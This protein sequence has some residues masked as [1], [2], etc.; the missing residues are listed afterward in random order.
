MNMG[1]SDNGETSPSTSKIYGESAVVALAR[2]VRAA[3]ERIAPYI[4]RTPTVR[5][6]WLDADGREV[7]GKLECWQVSG[8]FKARGAFN[9]LSTFGPGQLS[10][11]ASAGNHGLAVAAAAQVLGQSARVFVPTSASELKVRRIVESGAAITVVG[12]DLREATDQAVK[13]AEEHSV[14]F[15]SPYANWDV[16]AGQ[17]TC[18]AEAVQDVG[19]FDTVIVPLGGGGLLSGVGAYAADRLPGTHLIA[20]HPAVFNRPF[21]KH[22]VDACLRMATPP[23]YADGLAVQHT[24]A[25]PLAEV[26]NRLLFEICAVT[27]S[28][29]VLGI[30]ALLHEHSL[31]VEGAG[32]TATAALLSGKVQARTGRTLLVLSGGNISSSALARAVVTEV[33]DKRLR[34]ALGLRHYMPVLESESGARS[35]GRDYGDQHHIDSHDVTVL[36]TETETFNSFPDGWAKRSLELEDITV[37]AQDH[38]NYL[39]ALALPRTGMQYRVLAKLQ[40]L[41]EELAQSLN[42]LDGGVPQILSGDQEDVVRLLLR[43]RETLSNGLE[44]ASP[45]YDQSGRVNFYDPSAQAAGGVNYARYGT[46]DLRTLELGL[47]EMLGFAYDGLEVLATSS[48]MAAFQVIESLLLRHVLGPGDVVAYAPYIYFE[49]AEEF[50]GLHFLG[51]IRATG[52]GSDELVRVVEDNNARVLFVDPVNNIAGLPVVD[53]ERLANLIESR[54]GWADRWLVIDGTMVSGGVNVFD[55]FCAPGHPRVLYYES[56]SKYSQFGLDLQMAGVCVVPREFAAKARSIRRNTGTILYP[57][58]VARFPRADRAAYLRRMRRMSAN[59]SLM[60]SI[61]REDERIAPHI[62]IGCVDDWMEREWAH[63]GAVL[64]IEFRQTGLNNRDG[65]EAV[66]ERMLVSARAFSA[67]LVKGLSFGFST[68]RVS[69]ASSMAEGSDPF[70]RFSVGI[71]EPGEVRRLASIVASAVA[72]Y[73]EIFAPVTAGLLVRPPSEHGSPSTNQVRV[74]PGI[75]IR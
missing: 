32:A 69:A 53:L 28:E 74:V 67:P 64:T 48:G 61:L 65:L 12:R 5:L 42:P 62:H 26:L 37:R 18:L 50:Q 58:A 29:I 51:H 17:G 66:I 49:A 72:D 20:T 6:P 15:I 23:T 3:H 22:S 11:T 39:D 35:T 36:P 45:A 1:G 38:R 57:D 31:L 54:A 59:A 40:T 60:A 52:Y 4:V 21:D 25:N 44:W 46:A 34:T 14:P 30:Y 9:A 75:G 8:S 43:M 71:E 24:F 63:G 10:I 55:L 56:A 68:T 33:D 27:E 13:Y 73:L 70:L 41:A 7:W 16:A 19:D 47:A 2:E